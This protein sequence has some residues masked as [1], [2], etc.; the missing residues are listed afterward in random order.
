[1]KKFTLLI[2]TMSVFLIFCYAVTFA[3]DTESAQ[4][5]Q[6]LTASTQEHDDIMA[7]P[8]SAMDMA[9]TEQSG[10]TN[11]MTQNYMQQAAEAVPK[12]IVGNI[13]ATTLITNYFGAAT[14]VTR[15]SQGGAA[16]S[17]FI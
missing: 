5:T 4:T 15:R 7:R 9:L 13:G 12:Y 1:M 3:A 11:T 2:L 16:H 17:A 10:Q 8:S 6:I 14:T